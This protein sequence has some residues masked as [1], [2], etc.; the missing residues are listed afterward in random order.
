MVYIK[1]LGYRKYLKHL[2]RAVTYLA[3]TTP[4]IQNQYHNLI[5]S[6]LFMI[7]NHHF[8]SY[9]ANSTKVKKYK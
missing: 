5:F 4:P 6:L 8:V 7:W 3:A 2:V 1:S 9:G